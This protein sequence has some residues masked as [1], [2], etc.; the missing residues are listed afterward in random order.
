MKE[1]LRIITWGGI[2]DAI[3]L[4]P[5]LKTLKKT[6]ANVEV[7]VYCIDTDHEQVLRHNPNID[8][9]RL[10]RFRSAPIDYLRY[11]LHNGHFFTPSYGT[12]RPSLH[13]RHSASRLMAEMFG[14]NLTPDSRP[15]IFLTSEE[16]TRGLRMLAHMNSALVIHTGARS[17]VNRKWPTERWASLVQ[18]YPDFTFY[19]L[20]VT[21]DDRVPGCIDLRGKLSL[22]E[23]FSVIRGAKL[24][25]GTD[26]SLSHA[27]T[28]LGVPAVVLFGPSVPQIWGHTN[29]TNIYKGLRCSP[30]VD[31][32][33]GAP[34]PYDQ[35]CMKDISVDEVA[36]AVSEK[37]VIS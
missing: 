18:L 19:Q 7:R 36:V 20:G 24:F 35:R 8:V 37:V 14:V 13:S 2:G 1:T 30:C 22:R 16:E 6:S 12:M 23:T 5:L 15:E 9:L 29:N 25:I 28:A 26:S 31:I 21:A 32:L 34:C 10:A 3:L 33:C 4:T 27:A 11:L 17:S